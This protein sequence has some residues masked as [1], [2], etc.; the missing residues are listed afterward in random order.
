MLKSTI[1]VKAICDYRQ[2]E[3]RRQKGLP[4]GDGQKEGRLEALSYIYD[5]KEKNQMIEF[6]KIRT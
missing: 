3:V 1:S 6:L 2:I 5:Y 4:S